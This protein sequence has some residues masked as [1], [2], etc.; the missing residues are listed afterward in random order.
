MFH[1]IQKVTSKIA[2]KRTYE[3]SIHKQRLKS[4]Q[5]NNESTKQNSTPNDILSQ[6][7]LDKFQAEGLSVSEE[8]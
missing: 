8:K 3:A 6:C 7:S 2:T 1:Q 4:N 5:E